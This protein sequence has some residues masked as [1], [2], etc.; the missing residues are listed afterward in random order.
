MVRGQE[1]IGPAAVTLRE[2]RNSC[3]LFFLLEF[4]AWYRSNSHC[5]TA[6][7]RGRRNWSTSR[8]PSSRTTSITYPS[9]LSSLENSVPVGSATRPPPS[10]ITTVTLREKKSLFVCCSSCL[11]FDLVP[12]PL[13][14]SHGTPRGRRNWSTSR[15]PSSR[16]TSITYPSAL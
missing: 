5:H 9:A 13:P 11:R 4:L 6:P 8:P 15:P 2:K 14:L 7:P 16:T 3:C 12:L 1:Q 10:S